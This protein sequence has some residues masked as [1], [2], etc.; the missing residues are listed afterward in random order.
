MVSYIACKNY[1]RLT[2][3]VQIG[4]TLDIVLS[5]KIMLT[6]FVTPNLYGA[7]RTKQLQHYTHPHI[8]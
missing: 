2:I 7:E 4:P 1:R 6:G 3:L 8:P 5:Q